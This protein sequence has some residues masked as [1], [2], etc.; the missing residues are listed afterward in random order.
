MLA[1]PPAPAAGGVLV[2]AG[3]IV[4][5]MGGFALGQ[6]TIGFFVGLGLGIAAAVAIWLRGR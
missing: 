1:P 2:A 4:G 6:T 3:A 5:A